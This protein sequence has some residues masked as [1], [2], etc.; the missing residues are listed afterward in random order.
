MLKLLSDIL[1]DR[2]IEKSALIPLIDLLIEFEKEVN[3][4]KQLF[5]YMEDSYKYIIQEQGNREQ[6][7]LQEIDYYKQDIQEY[8]KTYWELPAL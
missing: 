5:T 1:N 4:Q 3:K 6:E 2:K 7:L 8:I